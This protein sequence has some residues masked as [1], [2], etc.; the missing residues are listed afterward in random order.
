[1]WRVTRLPG[2]IGLLVFSTL[3]FTMGFHYFLPLNVVAESG[4]ILTLDLAVIDHIA[5]NETTETVFIHY[6]DGRSFLLLDKPRAFY[7]KA[8]LNRYDYKGLIREEQPGLIT[9]VPGELRDCNRYVDNIDIF[10][11]R[12]F[13]YVSPTMFIL[14]QDPADFTDCPCELKVI[15]NKNPQCPVIHHRTKKKIIDQARECG[16]GDW[17][18]V[19]KCRK[20]KK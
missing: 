12:G 20:N 17:F 14:I 16:L 11:V 18:P 1:M 13:V 3:L 5:T 10:H 19:R 6:Q 15:R 4:E 2:I 9:S 8:G 7:R